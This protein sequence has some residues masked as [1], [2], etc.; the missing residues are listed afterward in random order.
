MEEEYWMWGHRTVG[1]CQRVTFRHVHQRTQSKRQVS[2]NTCGTRHPSTTPTPP[3]HVRRAR[4]CMKLLLMPAAPTHINM[5]L[6]NMA[7]KNTG[8]PSSRLLLSSCPL[9]TP[10]AAVE[11]GNSSLGGPVETGSNHC[12]DVLVECWR[13]SRGP[14]R[15]SW[16]NSEHK[17]CPTVRWRDC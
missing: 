7:S 1:T 16:R 12:W 10:S 13:R 3:P 17:G 15:T 6:P 4:H 8:C 5:N 11:T 14:C 9:P 2:R